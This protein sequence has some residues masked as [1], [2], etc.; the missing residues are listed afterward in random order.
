M[1][2]SIKS[3]TFGS[4][5]KDWLGSGHGIDTNRS[6]TLDATL[7]L[8]D[9]ADGDVPS[10]VVVGKVTATGRYGPYDD[11]AVDGRAV[12]QG[13]LFDGVTVEAGANAGA[14]LLRHG[15]IVE[16]KLPASH[17]LDAAGKVDL[18]LIDYV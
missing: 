13:H 18:K 3:E 16:A 10:G 4:D 12:A 9:F 14:A 8:A 1:D 11:T 2:P 7:I 17:G 15:Q 5:R 6:V